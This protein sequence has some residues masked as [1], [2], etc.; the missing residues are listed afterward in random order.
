V[1]RNGIDMDPLAKYGPPGKQFSYMEVLG[2]AAAEVMREVWEPVA[3]R[4]SV[5]ALQP[6][7]LA[8]PLGLLCSCT[9]PSFAPCV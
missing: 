2:W 3:G 9:R 6:C 1:W 5:S 4:V 7:S 8:A